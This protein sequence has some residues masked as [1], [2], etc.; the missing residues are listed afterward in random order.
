MQ[1]TLIIHVLFLGEC[2]LQL[3][4]C[5]RD[6]GLMVFPEQMGNTE[7]KLEKA[8]EANGPLMTLPVW[9][10]CH[11]ELRTSTRVKR[12]FDFMANEIQTLY[13]YGQG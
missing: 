8:F 7:D 4:I 9:L 1:K 13:Q 2:T 12:V 5:K 3:E 11:K 10:V 6:L